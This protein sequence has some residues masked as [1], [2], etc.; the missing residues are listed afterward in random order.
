MENKELNEKESIAIIAQMLE[1]TKNKLERSSGVPFLIWGYTTTIISLLVYFLA[2]KFYPSMWPQ[3][4]WFAIPII[5][6]ISM[7]ISQKNKVKDVVTYIDKVIS[8]IWIVFGIGA[9][10]V[11]IVAFS[12][13]S[14]FPILFI[15]VLLMG[16]GASLTGLVIKFKPMIY[17][18]FISMAIS[19]LFFVFKGLDSILI[20]AAVFLIMMVVPGH[21]LN[22]RAKKLCSKN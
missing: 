8:Y 9:L 5:G 2:I 20:F 16:M 17:A 15:T 7:G 3:F 12:T 11:S 22:A 21:I 6:S 10:L 4:I 1:N 18:G 13:R 19:L 14:S